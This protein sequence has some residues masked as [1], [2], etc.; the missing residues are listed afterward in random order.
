MGRATQPRKIPTGYHRVSLNNKE[1]LLVTL[2]VT[3]SEQRNF[4]MKQNDFTGFVLRSF[5]MTTEIVEAT[6][7]S[8]LDKSFKDLSIVVPQ[9]ASIVAIVGRGDETVEDFA[10][11]LYHTGISV[12]PYLMSRNFDGTGQRLGQMEK[13]YKWFVQCDN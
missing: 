8:L 6:S 10:D 12:D 9:L 11:H 2:R 13:T 7:R 1:F 4:R 5:T 3:G